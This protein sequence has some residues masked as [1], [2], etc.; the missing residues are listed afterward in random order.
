MM[1]KEKGCSLSGSSVFVFLEGA[2][3]SE[4]ELLA[5]EESGMGA[6]RFPLLFCIDFMSKKE[7]RVR[8]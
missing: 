7:G 2:L 8:C 5:L 3:E 4:E 1:Q 6:R